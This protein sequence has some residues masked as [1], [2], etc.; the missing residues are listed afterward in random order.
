MEQVSPACNS[1][2][3]SARFRGPSD[4]CPAITGRTVASL[5]RWCCWRCYFPLYPSDLPA[6]RRCHTM[7][8]STSLFRQA[9]QSV[10]W[11][12]PNGPCRVHLLSSMAST[13]FLSILL[14]NRRT[15]HGSARPS[16]RQMPRAVSRD[17]KGERSAIGLDRCWDFVCAQA[18]AFHQSNEGGVLT[19]CKSPTAHCVLASILMRS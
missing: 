19:V 11:K 14:F 12:M 4:L 5:R 15:G 6:P 7:L 2:S 18:S 8:R 10:Y 17:K 1:L 13:E 16:R 3:T 9:K